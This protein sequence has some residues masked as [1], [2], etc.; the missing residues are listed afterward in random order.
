MSRFI[1]GIALLCSCLMVAC[2][3]SESGYATLEPVVRDV[4]VARPIPDFGEIKETRAKKDAFF[5]YMSELLRQA[6]AEVWQ[7]R[8]LVLQLEAR[9]EKQQLSES[10]L[11]LLA[12]LTQYYRL[13]LPVPLTDA[14]FSELLERVDV[15]PIS[16]ALAQSANESGW[17]TSRFARQGRNFYGIWCYRPGCGIRPSRQPAGTSHEVQKFATV[18]DGVR[19]YIHMINT[20]KS[21]AQLRELRAG[22]RA[23]EE[24]P[25]GTELA[26]G[27][28]RYSERGGA[29]VAEIRN[30]IRQN[31]LSNYAI[32][33]RAWDGAAEDYPLTAAR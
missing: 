8:Q 25:T 21:Y 24:K 15:I 1:L 4:A 19:F 26:G 22:G 29:Y 20:R 31:K 5:V 33:W 14:V 2:T 28:T 30:M 3:S 27:L 16:L 11:E 10:D 18:Q 9:F 6:N 13:E 32:D 23:E 17:G 7:E 12:G